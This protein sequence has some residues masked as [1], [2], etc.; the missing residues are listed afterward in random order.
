MD[1]NALVDDLNARNLPGVRFRPTWFTPWI[2]KHPGDLCGGAQSHVTD[3]DAFAPVSTGIHILHAL[4][5][6]PDSRFTWRE[7]AVAGMSHG[8]LYGNTELHDLLNAGESA[9]SVI[10]IWQPELD[11]WVDRAKAFHLY[12]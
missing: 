12:Q 9:E 1:A 5:H 11:E 3:L 10:A 4:M 8:R 2:S 6:L 7:G